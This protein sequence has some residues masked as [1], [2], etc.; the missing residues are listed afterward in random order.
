MSAYFGLDLDRLLGLWSVPP[1]DR[2]DAYAD[3]AALY[4]DPVTINDSPTPLQDLVAR[5]QA[6]N[7]A[8]SD[9]QSEILD[10]VA[11]R[12]K[13]AVAFRRHAT[14]TGTWSSPLGDLPATHERVTIMGL[15]IFTITDGRITAI[16]VLGDDLAVLL[17]AAGRRL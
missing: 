7:E 15:D 6:I 3:F 11:A 2:H 5:A 8:F 12:S 9:Q 10:V 1:A 14:H 16:R 13:L 4:D 17:T